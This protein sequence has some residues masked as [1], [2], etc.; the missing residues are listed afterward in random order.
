MAYVSNTDPAIKRLQAQGTSTG[1]ANAPSAP[2]A[3]TN[4]YVSDTDPAI[5]RL[6]GESVYIPSADPLMESASK[7]AVT[8]PDVKPQATPNL[9]INAF[10]AGDTSS[11]A[12]LMGNVFGAAG[13]GIA[14]SAVETAGQLTQPQGLTIGENAR[15]AAQ[16]KGTQEEIAKAEKEKADRIRENIQKPLYETSDKLQAKSQQLTENAKEGLDSVGRFIVDAA[17]TGTQLAGDVALGAINPALGTASMA[18]RA[19]GGSAQEARQAGATETQQQIYGL[20]N[21]AVAVGVEKLAQVGKLFKTAYGGSVAGGSVDDVLTKLT[22]KITKSPVAQRIIASALGEA[23][24]E[25]L[26]TLLQ[27]VLKII[28]DKGAELNSTWFGN[29]EELTDYL[30]DVGYSML[31][32]GTLGAFG[33]GGNASTPARTG[34]EAN[35]PTPNATAPRVEVEG[36]TDTP[37]VQNATEGATKAIAANEPITSKMVA[38][39]AKDPAQLAQLGIDPNGK[40]A[41]QL[42]AEVKAALEQRK[43]PVETVA[44]NATVPTVT[45]NDVTSADI[46][47]VNS[48]GAAHPSQLPFSHAETLY[49]VIDGKANSVRPDDV[50]RSVDGKTRVSET[51]STVKGAAA[52]PD[53]FVPILE[54]ATM[55]GDFSYIPITNN[56]TVQ[57]VVAKIEG[58]NFRESIADWTADVRNGK[59]DANTIIMGQLL[60][61]NA[62]NSGDTQLALDILTDYQRL[63]RKAAQAL[64]AMSI[65][66]K[67][68]PENRLYMIRRSVRSM[69]DDLD[70]DVPVTIDPVLEQAYLNAKTDAEADAVLNSIARDVASQLRTRKIDIWNTLRYTNMLFNLKTQVRNVV[71]NVGMYGISGVKNAISAGLQKLSKGAE[72]TR[73]LIVDPEY[74]SVGKA[75]FE[76]VKSIIL[77]DGKYQEGSVAADE[78]KRM[79][80]DAVRVNQTGNKAV[81]VFLTPLEKANKATQWMMN[82]EV[83]GDS[84]FARANYAR[85][86]GGYLKAQGITPQQWNDTT[87]Q[88][89]NAKTVEKA[90]AFAIKDAQENTFR[91]SNKLADWIS[92]LGRSNSTP[93]AVKVVSEGLMPFRKTPANILI[94][95]EEYSPLGLFNTAVKAAQSK[96]GSGEVNANDVVEQ[97]AKTLTGT[98]LFALG[99]LGAA[100]GFLRGAEDDDKNQAALDDLAGHQPYSIEIGDKSYTLDWLT[101]A[102]MPLFMGVELM[103]EIA[104]NGLTLNAVEGALTSMPE[105]MLEMSFMSGVADAL[106]NIKYSDNNVIQLALNLGVS[107]LTQGLTSTLGGQIERTFEP[108]RMMTYVDKNSG[109]PTWLQYALGKASAKIPYWDYQQTE[110]IDPFGNTESN[111]TFAERAFNNF[112]A[113]WYSSTIKSDPV[114]TEIQRLYDATGEAGVV[115]DNAPKQFT[116]DG[117][118]INLTAEQYNKYATTRGGE[119]Y[120]LMEGIVNSTTYKGYTDEQKVKAIERASDYAN[121]V[122]KAEVSDYTPDGWAGR[123]KQNNVKPTDY[124]SFLSLVDK[125]GDGNSSISQD[126]A[127]SAL[128]KMNLTRS[129]KANI[130]EVVGYK[131]GGKSW[132]TNPYK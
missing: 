126:E 127:K 12:K 122:A 73:S 98:G 61:N 116:V 79:V 113:P 63:G 9:N 27:P 114:A 53:D 119:L 101:P 74:R 104:E 42:R 68:T 4:T 58:R 75:D 8:T 30:A 1:G 2:K 48:V 82:N 108:N 6:R 35:A 125:I 37:A 10:G 31:L 44:N 51:V 120:N 59:A 87:W 43:A 99:M 77:R 76:K 7:P 54:N 67:L 83:F 112:L 46:K 28:Y 24:E 65:L 93:A 105:P 92:R 49:G 96:K 97:L 95:A 69:V 16:G 71:G 18:T 33:G 40:S 91:D 50:P 103:N 118:D 21:A 100:K 26:E 5:K 17:I 22:S 57:K 110:Y 78:F 70:L 32:G 81:N 36:D 66:Q 131:S 47:E 15:L 14:A 45:A 94:R 88:A 52:T 106:D 55:N 72:N 84:A 39:M 41:S 19:F 129:Q 85:A 109:T 107:Y 38:E 132:K 102:S 89:N 128:D 64:Q 25:G 121:K 3:S 11:G 62:V 60:Y 20:A 123:V 124:I 29:A 34:V 56:D 117:K 80:E 115:P 23:G 90:R 130:W 86:L 111:G 13:T